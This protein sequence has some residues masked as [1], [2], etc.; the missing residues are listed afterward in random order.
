M[1]GSRKYPY[2]QHGIENSKGL[3]GGEG[4]RPRKLQ[5]GGDWTIKITFQGINFGLSMRIAT[6]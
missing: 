2:P 1:C 3:G 5:R 6:Y 4:Q